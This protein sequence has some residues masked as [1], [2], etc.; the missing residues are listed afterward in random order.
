[1]GG[2]QLP[3]VPEEIAECVCGRKQDEIEVKRLQAEIFENF[4]ERI[5]L[6]RALIELEEQND[7]NFLEIRKKQAEV[8]LWKKQEVG[9]GPFTPDPTRPKSAVPPQIRNIF[10][11]I[12]TLKVNTDRNNQRKELMLGQLH[13]N[14]QR[15]K[16]IRE[17]LSTSIRTQEKREFLELLI[18]NHILEQTNV[19]L[20]IQLQIQEKTINDLQSLLQAQK[21]LLEEHHIDDGSELLGGL[22]QMITPQGIEAEEEEVNEEELE[23]QGYDINE[24]VE[25]EDEEQPFEGDEDFETSDYL[26]AT[27]KV[28][29]DIDK[30][31][32]QG[33]FM[34]Q[35]KGLIKRTEEAKGRAEAREEES[36]GRGEAQP[37]PVAPTMGL[38]I[39][40]RAMDDGLAKK[41]QAPK[42]AKPAKK[43][44]GVG[45]FSKKK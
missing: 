23:K 14:M 25:D 16:A 30:H 40:G 26:L 29:E 21:K 27:S 2:G 8:M 19:E 36:K 11:D 42:P 10:K 15:G 41:A 32:E 34:L 20:E 22:D 43:K 7:L 3:A 37:V 28:G 18:K 45:P 12:Q 24:P 39:N 31:E 17:S 44:P 38:M 1:M 33:G 6:R 9:E 5:Q 35:G 13:E 4:Q